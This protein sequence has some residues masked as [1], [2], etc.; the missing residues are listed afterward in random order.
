M[1][2]AISDSAGAEGAL[3]RPG[4]LVRMWAMQ[5]TTRLWSL[6]YGIVSSEY[7][8]GAGE[9]RHRIFWSHCGMRVGYSRRDI[10]M[11]IRDSRYEVVVF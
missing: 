10:D 3:F 9:R 1:G 6:G 5:E 8:N 4:T 2:A 11:D 7:V